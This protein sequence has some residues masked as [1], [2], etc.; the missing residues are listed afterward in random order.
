MGL[1]VAHACD[2]H[3]KLNRIRIG[4]SVPAHQH[5]LKRAEVVLSNRS[6]DGEFNVLGMR[7]ACTRQEEG[8]EER[9]D[10]HDVCTHGA[11]STKSHVFV[12]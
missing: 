10:H 11:E 2:I 4:L 9:A 12:K 5:D 1:P 7:R 8:S 6:Q 3:L